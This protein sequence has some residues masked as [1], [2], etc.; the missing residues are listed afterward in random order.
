EVVVSDPAPFAECVEA[1]RR[2]LPGTVNALCERRQQAVTD[3]LKGVLGE[4]ILADVSDHGPTIG[5]RNGRPQLPQPLP[6][7]HVGML[8]R[9]M[10]VRVVALVPSKP[11]VTEG[12]HCRRF[13]RA[14]AQ[15]G[16][17]SEPEKLMGS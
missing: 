1:L 14:R 10:M 16:A 9:R 15:R 11:G 13:A 12:A 17:K 6:G 8:G 7:L 4:P 2:L 5:R 3:E